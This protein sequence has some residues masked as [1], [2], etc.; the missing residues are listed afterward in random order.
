[1][2]E[3]ILAE[4]IE[5][6]YHDRDAGI[7]LY[8]G[9]CR[10]ILPRL[11]AASVDLIFTSPPYNLGTSPGGC[12]SGFY[13]PSRGGRSAT[14][15]SNFNGYDIHDDAMPMEE[16][17]TWQ[18]ETL[19][20]LWTVAGETGAIF[21]NHKPRLVFGQMWSPLDLNPGLPLRQIIT[22]DRGG[23]IAL[24]DG[25]YCPGYEWILLFAKP[26][27]R[28]MN[29]AASA[30]GDVWRI[31]F[32]TERNGHPAPFPVELPLTAIETVQC[33]TVLDPFCGVGSTLVAAK[34]A[35]KSAIGIELNPD[36]CAMAVQR[37]ERSQYR[38][39]PLHQPA[40]VAEQL[41]LEER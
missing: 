2:D 30:I 19:A 26:Y 21:Y 18:R 16:Y 32:E 33:Q 5:P 1:M 22:W 36:Y 29:R 25:H 39:L 3:L 7:V 4:G 23:G 15:W 8:C 20:Q 38:M 9:D 34:Q 13:T 12:G 6:Y 17:I 14:K 10:E 35:G 11:A 31:R 41:A 37:L 40:P 24:G 27:F 28:L